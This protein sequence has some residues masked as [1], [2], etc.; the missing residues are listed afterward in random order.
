M[1]NG[2]ALKKFNVNQLNRSHV[3]LEFLFE[4][5]T[6]YALGVYKTFIESVVE[7]AQGQESVYGAGKLMDWK[8]GSLIEIMDHFGDDII[9]KIHMQ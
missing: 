8:F 1:L 2:R 9:S 7:A 5:N 4:G 3:S 6:F